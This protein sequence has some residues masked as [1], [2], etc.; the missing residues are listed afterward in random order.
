[1]KK[2]T[3]AKTQA[4]KD[5]IRHHKK[6]Y[7][8]VKKQKDPFEKPSQEKMFKALKETWDGLHCPLC[9]Y[10]KTKMSN[11]LH[12]YMFGLPRCSLCPLK[13]K[14]GNCSDPNS[15]NAWFKM[16]V[17]PTWKYWLINSKKLIEQLESLL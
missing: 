4:I 1:M 6:M 12:D 15:K 9:R 3:S 5:S 2:I 13:E 10:I 17:S 14:Y 8:W 7:N 16:H 11:S